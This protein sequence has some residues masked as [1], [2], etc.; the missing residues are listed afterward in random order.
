M[1]AAAPAESQERGVHI[2]RRDIM[3]DGSAEDRSHFVVDVITLLQRGSVV[4]GTWSAAV[5]DQVIGLQVGRGDVPADAVRHTAGRIEVTSSIPPG[6]NRLVLHYVLPPAVRRWELELDAPV[7]TL[8]VSARSGD[9]IARGPRFE[10]RVLGRTASAVRSQLATGL[11]PGTIIRFV[12]ARRRETP[13]E[14]WWLIVLG[15]VAALLGALVRWARSTG[16]LAR[17]W[18]TV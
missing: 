8:S 16:G 18:V 6:P 5:P 15:A 12:P 11:A 1:A 10:E 2:V 4:S 17:E 14:Y 13:V 3:V 9:V 7:D